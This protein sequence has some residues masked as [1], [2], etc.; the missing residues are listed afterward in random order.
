MHLQILRLKRMNR[1]S[2]VTLGE[3]RPG[4]LDSRVH[5]T[6][7]RM[8]VNMDTEPTDWE[9]LQLWEAHFTRIQKPGKG[10]LDFII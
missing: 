5:K 10:R 8:A 4:D 3:T 6:G 2:S 9:L 1:P 7:M